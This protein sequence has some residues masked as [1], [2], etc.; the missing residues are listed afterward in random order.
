MDARFEMLDLVVE[1]LHAVSDIHLVSHSRPLR[2]LAINFA[3]GFLAD[4]PARNLSYR[5]R[6]WRRR[7]GARIGDR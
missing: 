7:S 6:R 2:H 3:Q 4:D 5:F 1:L